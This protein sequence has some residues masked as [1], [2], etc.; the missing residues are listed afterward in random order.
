MHSSTPNSPPIFLLG[1]MGSGKS[2]LGQ[3]LAEELGYDFADTDTLIAERCAKSVAAI[4]EEEGE[5]RF[6]RYEQEILHALFG[7]ERLVVACG[8]GLPCFYDNMERMNACGITVY[9]Q[10]LPEQ[11]VQR[12]EGHKSTHRPLLQ[13]KTG[14]ALRQYIEESLFRR[15][16]YYNQASIIIDTAVNPLA[17][18]MEQ[19]SQ[20]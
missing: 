2:T 17:H 3:A 13:G 6:R 9:L 15:E 7:R 1:F 19:L 20:R 11:L 4:F 8:G 16:Q 12:I 18:L 5:E 14:P 10:A